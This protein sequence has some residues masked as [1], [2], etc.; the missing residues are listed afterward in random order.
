MHLLISGMFCNNGCFFFFSFLIRIMCI[1][2]VVQRAE[3]IHETQVGF[4]LECQKIIHD[5]CNINVFLHEVLFL[6][7][8]YPFLSD[9]L[10][11]SCKRYLEVNMSYV[12][13][14]ETARTD[15]NTVITLEA[16]RRA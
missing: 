7:T 16:T 9:V 15:R 1:E 8:V 13:V 5:I 4:S 12:I 14:T 10:C 11:S 2:I 3:S 6:N